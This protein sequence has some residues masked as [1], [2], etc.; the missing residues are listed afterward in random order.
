MNEHTVAEIDVSEIQLLDEVQSR[1]DL[2]KGAIKE[3]AEK[4]KDG[5]AFPPIVVFQRGEECVC[6]DGF[7]RVHA[8]RKAGVEKIAAEVREGDRRD[9]IRH[10]VGAN[11]T[12]GVRRKNADKRRAVKMLLGDAEWGELAD[13]EI[14]R[15]AGVTHPLVSKIRKELAGNGYQSDRPLDTADGQQAV[16][17]TDENLGVEPGPEADAEPPGAEEALADPPDSRPDNTLDAVAGQ[18]PEH[19]DPEE[20]SEEDPGK[21]ATADADSDV[22]HATEADPDEDAVAPALAGVSPE[23]ILA[24]AVQAYAEHGRGRIQQIEEAVT[25]GET[26]VKQAY[27]DITGVMVWA[28]EAFS[29]AQTDVTHAVG[30]AIGPA[31]TRIGEAQLTSHDRPQAGGS[32]ASNADDHAA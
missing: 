27:R 23:Q 16:A 3:F 21:I 8:A 11:V 6:A 10:S 31:R 29:A 25:S 5:V 22:T 15:L 12:H 28:K 26:T 17:E 19:E 18:Q 13:R 1:V 14:G 30:S 7:H 24:A 9:A 4:I 32:E 2:D 20:D